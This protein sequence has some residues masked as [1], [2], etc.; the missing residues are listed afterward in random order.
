MPD[1]LSYKMHVIKSFMQRY[2]FEL[3][4]F[5]GYIATYEKYGNGC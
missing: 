3:D 1:V 2:Q 4:L 5:F